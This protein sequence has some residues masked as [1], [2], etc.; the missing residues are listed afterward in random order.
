MHYD[1]DS[2]NKAFMQNRYKKSRKTW[3]CRFQ[4]TS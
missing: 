3:T 1:L 4:T 2:K